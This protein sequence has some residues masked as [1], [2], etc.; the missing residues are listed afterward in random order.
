MR[1]SYVACVYV[2]VFYISFN[3][4]E[5]SIVKLWKYVTSISVAHISCYLN[6]ACCYIN[7]REV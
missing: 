7:A 5:M 6:I 2:S 1:E 4:N 3:F